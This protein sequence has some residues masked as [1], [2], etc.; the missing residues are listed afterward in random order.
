M[1]KE[2]DGFSIDVQKE[3][4]NLVVRFDVTNLPFGHTQPPVIVRPGEIFI[5]S[6]GNLRQEISN[7]GEGRKKQ[8]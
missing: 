8:D 6:Q 5:V 1:R 4:V 3:G 7:N 2:F